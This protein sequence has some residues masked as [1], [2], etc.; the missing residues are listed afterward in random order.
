MNDLRRVRFCKLTDL[1][2]K[3]NWI[4]AGVDIISKIVKK[5]GPSRVDLQGETV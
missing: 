4:L 3:K 1:F 2:S 5:T